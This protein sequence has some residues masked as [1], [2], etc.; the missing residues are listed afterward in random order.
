MNEH[1]IGIDLGT[2]N[3]S[4]AVYRD[5]NVEIVPIGQGLIMPSYVGLTPDDSLIVGAEARNQYVLYPE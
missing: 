2:T 5:G 3:S 4:V 1:I